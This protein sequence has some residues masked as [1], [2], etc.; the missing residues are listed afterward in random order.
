[1]WAG[2][3][4]LV[5]QQAVANGK[6]TVG[7]LNPTIYALVSENLYHR[8]PRHHRRQQRLFRSEG[9]RFG[10][11]LGQSE[12]GRP[13]HRACRNQVTKNAKPWRDFGPAFFL[14][15]YAFSTNSQQIGSPR[16][17]S[18]VIS[19]LTRRN[20]VPANEPYRFAPDLYNPPVRISR[21]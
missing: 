12:W 7:F 19:S 1:M 16:N 13:H 3:M 11:R 10:D 4:A 21:F 17:A 20:S 8:F 6:T 14:A 5:N 9:L 2:Y 15:S 18:S